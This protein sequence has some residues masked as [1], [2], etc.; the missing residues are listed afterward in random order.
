MGSG[1]CRERLVGHEGPIWCMQSDGGN[2]VASAGDDGTLRLW[3]LHTH[4][5][6]AEDQTGFWEPVAFLLRVAGASVG[7]S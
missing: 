1:A 2:L 5:C 3:D 7:H 6:G 4:R